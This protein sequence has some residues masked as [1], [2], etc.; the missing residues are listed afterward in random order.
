M[1]IGSLH[2]ITPLTVKDQKRRSK[3]VIA[4]GRETDPQTPR[5]SQ[6]K[7][8]RKWE[9]LQIYRRPF[10]K[11]VAAG[12]LTLDYHGYVKRLCVIEQCCEM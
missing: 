1:K 3:R 6:K 2:K 10:V 5:G 8:K 11:D 7:S 9:W 4:A 12:V